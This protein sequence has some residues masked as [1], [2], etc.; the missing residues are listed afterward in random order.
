MLLLCAAPDLH[1]LKHQPSHILLPDR[2]LPAL[3]HGGY[4]LLHGG[5]GARGFPAALSLFID[6]VLR[7]LAAEEL[8]FDDFELSERLC[9]LVTALNL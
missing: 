7:R 2:P 9:R 8:L 1:G 6:R 5:R 3:Q 4:D